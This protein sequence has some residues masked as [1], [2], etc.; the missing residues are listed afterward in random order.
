MVLYVSYNYFLLIIFF[1]FFMHS[2]SSPI[3]HFPHFISIF[4]IKKFHLLN[5]T[6]NLPRPIH[7][8]GSS[9]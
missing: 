3:E 7:I 8:S 4:L 2:Y 5:I 6:N 1:I 9:V